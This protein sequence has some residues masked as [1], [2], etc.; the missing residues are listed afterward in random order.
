[1]INEN[2]H[3]NPYKKSNW[4]K[5]KKKTEIIML[6]IICALIKTTSVEILKILI[7]IMVMVKVIT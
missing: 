4:K 7:T 5:N 6:L 2:D 1:M 3:I